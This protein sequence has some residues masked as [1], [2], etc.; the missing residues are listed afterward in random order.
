MPW[1]TV[2]KHFA[3]DMKSLVQQKAYDRVEERLQAAIAVKSKYPVKSDMLIVATPSLTSLML[4]AY[5]D[6]VEREVEMKL[7]RKHYPEALAYLAEVEKKGKSK[8]HRARYFAIEEKT[9]SWLV[10]NPL[11]EF[12]QALLGLGEGGPDFASRKA[13]LV[14]AGDLYNDLFVVLERSKS[15][16]WEAFKMLY[17]WVETL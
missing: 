17:S 10:A 13:A 8:G 11:Y 9:R 1:N 6:E 15:M 5:F 12:E 14:R 4:Q 16:R 7:S 2:V 3:D